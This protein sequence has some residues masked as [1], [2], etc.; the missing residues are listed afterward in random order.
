MAAALTA[1]AVALESFPAFA[2]LLMEGSLALGVMA[3]AGLAGGWIGL[4]VGLRHAPR[5]DRLI[6]GAGL[7][8]GC[9]ALAMLGL[10]M[11]GWLTRGIALALVGIAAIAGL[12]RLGIELHEAGHLK[13]GRTTAAPPDSAG[14]APASRPSGWH[15]LWLAVCPF[16][17]VM[18][19][20]ACLPPGLLWAEEGMG[21]DV[22]EYHLAVPKTFA[23]QGRITFLPHNV[24]SNFPLNSEMLSLLMMLLRGDAIEASYMAVAANAGLAGLFIAAAWLAGSRFSPAA[25][26][27]AGVLAG[28]TPWVAYLAGIAYV[29]PG[30][31]AL[32][33]CALAAAIRPVA[34]AGASPSGRRVA[35]PD[36]AALPAGLLA[37]LA[38]GFKYTAVPLIALPVALSFLAARTSAARQVRALAIYGCGALITFSPWMARN[39]ANTG[40]P[41]FPLAY[42]VFGDRSGT[43]DQELHA[44]WQKAHASPTA[45]KTTD[46][47]IRRA[48]SRTIGDSR[49]GAVT[50]ALAA[51]GAWRRRDQWTAALLG[52][53]ALQVI[54][55]LAATHLFARFAVVL[56]IPLVVLAGRAAE[57]A[58]D[59]PRRTWPALLAGLL[60]IGAGWNL[61]HLGRLYYH[62]TRPGGEPIRAY[63][64][65]D[66]FTQ[67]DWPGM[68][69]LGAINAA[70]SEA[71][72]MLVG[73]ARTFYIRP[74]CEYAV[75]FNRH[76]LAEAASASR[77][78]AAMLFWL[79]QRGVTHLLVHWAEIDRLSDTYG[80]YPELLDPGLYQGLAAVGLRRTADYALTKDLPPYATLYEVPRP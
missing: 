66:W 12:L 55:W 52:M 7:G 8:V 37:G 51:I 30:M 72:V 24:Y 11:A 2:V 76:P 56:L 77:D 27:V 28:V 79:R 80:F 63:G 78:P 60:L 23:E 65:T 67:G 3:A 4:C 22:L 13:I 14:G 45:E 71:R 41:F 31:L 57:A 64:R 43:W 42:S 33:M 38:C 68:E 21:Y 61:Y 59:K 74:P 15:W 19:L 17:A 18:L 69:Y 73:E 46:S 48:W 29:E 32:G 9:L 75:V 1:A 10:G 39:L 70:G 44:R 26:V 6:L 40:N 62:H 49:F 47:F 34:E 16:V 20:A 5:A 58:A 25:G 35:G 54:V 50:L 36:P 53:V